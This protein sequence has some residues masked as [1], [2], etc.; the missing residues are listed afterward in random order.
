MVD[1]WSIMVTSS[2]HPDDTKRN[3]RSDDMAHHDETYFN[4]NALEIGVE[5][6]HAATQHTSRANPS[7]SDFSGRKK[8]GTHVLENQ[9]KAELGLDRRRQTLAWGLSE[10]GEDPK[11][12]HPGVGGWVKI[13]N[14]YPI[15]AEILEPKLP[16]GARRTT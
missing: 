12:K 6:G 16:H 2:S 4:M 5:G 14:E 8:C 10:S 11:G 1:L 7:F 13:G 9:G 3:A 15:L